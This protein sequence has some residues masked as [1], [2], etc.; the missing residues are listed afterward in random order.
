MN[1]KMMKVIVLIASI[2]GLCAG[3]WTSNNSLY[4]PFTGE[5][6]YKANYGLGADRVDTRLSKE[7]YIG[8]PSYPTLASA[9]STIGPVSATI[10]LPAGSYVGDG[11]TV[12]ANIVIRPLKGALITVSSRATF[13]INGQ[14]QAP[15]S[16]IFSC[17]GTG[18]VVFGS[19]SV[20]E[21]Y[22]EWWGYSTDAAAAFTAAIQTGKTVRLQTGKTYPITTSVAVASTT[23]VQIIG[24][25]GTTIDGTSSS[26]SPFF[27]V[28][29]SRGSSAALAGNATA[30]DL[31]IASTLASSL[32][33]GDIILITSTNLFNLMKSYYFKGEMCEV[34]STAGNTINL[35]SSLYDSYSADATSVY[36]L[37]M[38]K[39]TLKNLTINCN[40]NIIG[41]EVNYGRNVVVENCAVSGARVHGIEVKYLFGA[42]IKDNYVTDC[43][44]SGTGTSYGIACSSSQNVLTIGN[45]LSG[46]RHGLQHGGWEPN[47]NI[48]VIGNTIDNYHP[49]GAPALDFHENNQYVVVK[50][51]T[52]KNG[53]IFCGIDGVFEGNQIFSYTYSG[54][55]LYQSSSHAYTII[56]GNTIKQYGV[57]TSYCGIEVDYNAASTVTQLLKMAD[58]S[59][60][61]AGAG[62]R[63]KAYASSYTGCSIA[64][65]V[66]ESNEVKVTGGHALDVQNQAN[67]V[68][69][70]GEVNGGSYI[71]TY[72]SGRAVDY[73]VYGTSGYI[74]FRDV[75]VKC[76][77]TTN[78]GFYLVGPVYCEVEGCHIEST[79]GGYY[80]LFNVNH[81]RFIRN[82]VINFG[83]YGGLGLGTAV[84]EI[85]SRDNLFSGNSGS[86][87]YSNAKILE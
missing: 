5:T 43:W 1:R 48:T 64:K 69:S 59:I 19:S 25:P 9:V 50:G 4:K 68:V 6:N 55:R 60:L 51:N 82:K 21:I 77:G 53:A 54:L 36:K 2:V 67:F 44:Y 81:L 61:S 16:Q 75:V 56:S 41:L 26:A 58:N 62:V 79:T 22:P 15:V 45:R 80:N 83:T 70:R 85:Y 29:G 33:A 71:T 57:G 47:R 84:V 76:G 24:G 27:T 46:G 30:G 31:S 11:I 74:K 49:S 52:I 20:D 14:L 35:K 7:H 34:A 87:A 42:T 28:G 12:P 32:S 18:K 72:P 63:I 38:P 10:V 73:E 23:G 66:L 13:T 39:L 40:A 3:S 65:L 8:D 17:S 78:Y 86:I 37:T